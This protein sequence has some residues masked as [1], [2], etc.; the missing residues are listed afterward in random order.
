MYQIVVFSPTES[1]LLF[2]SSPPRKRNKQWTNISEKVGSTDGASVTKK[3]CLIFVFL[4]LLVT[5]LIYFLVSAM[6]L[7]SG[8]CCVFAFCPFPCFCFWSLLC[9]WFIATAMM[10]LSGHCRF[11]LSGALHV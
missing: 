3:L 8:N 2:F 9:F 4:L 7:L 1:R 11:L 6:F 5:V 10:L